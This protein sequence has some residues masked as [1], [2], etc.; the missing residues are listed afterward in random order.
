[1][2]KLWAILNRR[3]PLFDHPLV[4]ALMYLLGGVFMNYALIH[5]LVTGRMIGRRTGFT[6]VEGRDSA[7]VLYWI[8]IAGLG[9]AVFGMDLWALWLVRNAWNSRSK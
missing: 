5:A 3:I 8:Y 9:V 1:M 7:P 4:S 6:G 2:K